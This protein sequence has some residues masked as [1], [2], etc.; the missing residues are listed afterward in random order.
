MARIKTLDQAAITIT[1]TTFNSRRIV[2]VRTLFQILR[3]LMS[4]D[5]AS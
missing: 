2:Q 3:E 4:R 1:I 5:K